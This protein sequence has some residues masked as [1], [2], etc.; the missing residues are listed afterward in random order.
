MLIPVADVGFQHAKPQRTKFSG[1]D[2]RERQYNLTADSILSDWQRCNLWTRKRTY[3]IKEAIFPTVRELGD[4]ALA[5]HLRHRNPKGDTATTLKGPRH[6]H[7]QMKSNTKLPPSFGKNPA[8][9][10]WTTPSKSRLPNLAEA[11]LRRRTIGVETFLSR[12]LAWLTGFRLKRQSVPFSILLLILLPPIS[13]CSVDMAGM[14]RAAA[15]SLVLA[16][17]T[18]STTSASGEACEMPESPL[19]SSLLQPA[20]GRTQRQPVPPPA[21]E[22]SPIS[23]QHKEAEAE[24]NEAAPATT[25]EIETTILSNGTVAP[26]TWTTTEAQK[27]GC[28]RLYPLLLTPLA[29]AAA[30]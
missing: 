22:S 10:A 5:S 6:C 26:V 30:M 13:S 2:A 7:P 17:Y 3:K 12:S 25:E 27:S 16:A 15:F 11:N 8:G 9:S 29:A 24:A 21:A 20:A 18:A 4:M 19:S 23:P 14:V 28:A 1:I